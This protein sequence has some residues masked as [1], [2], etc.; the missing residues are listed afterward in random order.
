MNFKTTIVL[1][2]LLAVAGIYLFFTRATGTPGTATKTES[3]LL[4]VDSADVTKV[5]IRPADGKPTVLEKSGT[6]WRLVEPV[7]A[8]A[9][10]FQVDDLLR[11]LTGLKSRGPV[12]ADQRAAAGLD[13]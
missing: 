7:S 1:I 2:I 11:E 9:D 8:P 13:H 10:T 4:P 6:E 5:A 12:D 3:K